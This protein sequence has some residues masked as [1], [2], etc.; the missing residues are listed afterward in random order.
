MNLRNCFVLLVVL[1]VG[2]YSVYASSGRRAI[3]LLPYEIDELCIQNATD[4]SNSVFVFDWNGTLVEG[5]ELINPEMVRVIR[6]L[7][8]KSTVIL[9]TNAGSADVSTFNYVIGLLE[10]HEICFSAGYLKDY[11]EPVGAARSLY[12][13][14]FKPK[15]LDRCHASAQ[16]GVIQTS[17]HNYPVNKGPILDDMFKH[18][19][20]DPVKVFCFEDSPSMVDSLAV[21]FAD[22]PGK[23]IVYEVHKNLSDLRQSVF[24]FATGD[25]SV[26][27][28]PRRDIY[29]LMSYVSPKVAE[30]MLGKLDGLLKVYNP[31]SFGELKNELGDI[32]RKHFSTG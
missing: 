14:E 25:V 10:L 28:A 5:S 4:L 1:C 6:E 7:K 20:V 31:L 30:D 27:N 18:S 2:E 26:H 16:Y 17:F 15:Y 9:L 29:L 12:G 24:T 19:G 32:M 3:S 13:D 23:C 8:E 11:D 22:R 21:A